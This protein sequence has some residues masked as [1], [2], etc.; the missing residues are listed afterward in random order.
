MRVTHTLTL[1]ARCPV[2]DARDVYECVIATD[3]CIEVESII[4]IAKVVAGMK[5][6]Q[7]NITQYIRQQLGTGVSVTTRGVHSGVNT[8]VTCP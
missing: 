5:A 7:E 3:R 8:E 6:Y 2:D 1:T 4:E